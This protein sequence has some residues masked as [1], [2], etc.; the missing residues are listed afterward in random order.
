MPIQC[1]QIEKLCISSV[2]E[3]LRSTSTSPS[4]TKSRVFMPDFLF[5]W[6]RDPSARIGSLEKRVYIWEGSGMR[7]LTNPPDGGE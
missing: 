3:K 6:G 5:G 4:Q 1:V 2:S 7:K